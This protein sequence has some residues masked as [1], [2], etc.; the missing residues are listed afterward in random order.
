[1]KQIEILDL[2]EDVRQLVGEC[3]LTGRQTLFMRNGR[4]VVTL[5]SYDEYFALRE[6]I[7]IANDE[8]TRAQIDAADEETKR[9]AMLLTEDLI[10]TRSAEDRIRIA[11]S[12][13]RTW[14]LLR[15]EE[16]A[17]I[18]EA[19]AMIDDDPIAGAPLFEPMRGLWSLRAGEFRVVYRIVAEARFVVILCLSR[20]SRGINGAGDGNVEC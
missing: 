13:E 9:G 20:A 16:R 3:E 12:V 19:L 18:S 7:D 5:V 4:P 6:T 11:E 1:M 14:Q 17:V 15:D 2:P 8:V 10:G